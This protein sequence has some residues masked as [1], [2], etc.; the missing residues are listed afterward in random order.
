MIKQKEAATLI[1][2]FWPYASGRIVLFLTE[3]RLPKRRILEENHSYL[4]YDTKYLK[5]YM[6]KIQGDQGE[7]WAAFTTLEVIIIL[8]VV[9][10][11]T[12]DGIT[13]GMKMYRKGNMSKD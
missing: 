9:K 13:H 6:H 1:L 12:L 8:M 11:M 2:R 4:V 7:G 3:M 5:K 10:E